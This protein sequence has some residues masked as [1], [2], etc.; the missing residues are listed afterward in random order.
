MV[1]A[2]ALCSGLPV[3]MYELENFKDLYTEG[4]IKVKE[5]DIQEFASLII[6]MISDNEYYLE[7]KPDE[8]SIRELT[9]FWKWETRSKIF[10]DFIDK[11]LKG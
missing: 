5:G 1:A 11:N 6:K 4:C 9:E 8:R 3:I 2:E 7:I 10:K